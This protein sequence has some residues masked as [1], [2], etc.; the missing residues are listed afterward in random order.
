MQRPCI[1]QPCCS[2]HGSLPSTC[3]SWRAASRFPALRTLASLQQPDSRR[4]AGGSCSRQA[5]RLKADAAA[6]ALGG[7]AA[8]AELL[9][10]GTPLGGQRQLGGRGGG[11]AGKL[12]VAVDVDEGAPGS[13]RL[14]PAA[15][16]SSV[17]GWQARVAM[18]L[19]RGRGMRCPTAGHAA[20]WHR[21]GCP[22]CAAVQTRSLACC[23]AA[24]VLGRFLHSLNQFLA[25]VEG[26]HFDVPDYFAYDF[27]KVG[28]RRALQIWSARERAGQRSRCAGR[29]AR[30]LHDGSTRGRAR[31]LASHP[32]PQRLARAA[33]VALL[34]GRVQ[35][36]RARVLHQRPFCGGHRGHRWCVLCGWD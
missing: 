15:L 20:V 2:H 10:L 33:G 19:S 14:R 5:E 23:P 1:E 8:S 16:R 17:G 36:A 12:K 32:G 7:R 26:K 31:T 35:P 18:N 28:R 29:R 25:E 11:R 30:T 22:P 34:P 13:A 9:S 6:G 21:R 4:P 27:A 24:A 3:R